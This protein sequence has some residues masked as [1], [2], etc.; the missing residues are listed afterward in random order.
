MMARQPRGCCRSEWGGR[1]KSSALLLVT[2][3]V[4]AALS[5]TCVV[6]WKWAKNCKT[7]GSWRSSSA[8]LAAGVVSSKPVVPNQSIVLLP[9]LWLLHF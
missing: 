4:V 1:A 5:L 2:G 3:G 9:P 8:R 7:W 6:Q